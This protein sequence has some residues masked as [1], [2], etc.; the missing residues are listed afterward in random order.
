[1]DKLLH[2]TLLFDFYSELLAEKQK[3]VYEMYY[4]DDFSLQEIAKHFN[5]SRQGVRDML[6]RSEASML[7]YEEAL[8]LVAK[9]LERAG[10]IEEISEVINV[11]LNPA[12]PEMA[13]ILM[14]IKSLTCRL[15]EV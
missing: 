15:S 6:K 13:L 7:E 5:I 11:G 12:N 10:L 4:G 9:H 1:M 8:S 14:K 3:Q 2:S